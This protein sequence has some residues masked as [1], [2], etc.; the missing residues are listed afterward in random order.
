MEIEV[1]IQLQQMPI[2]MLL[3]E[4]EELVDLVMTQKMLIT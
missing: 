3:L 1:E 2:V 4:V